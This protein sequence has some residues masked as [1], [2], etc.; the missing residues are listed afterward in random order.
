MF[1]QNAQG[2]WLLYRITAACG[3]GFLLSR[4]DQF[5]GLLN[6]KPFFATF[7]YPSVT[8]QAFKGNIQAQKQATDIVEDPSWSWY[9]LLSTSWWN[10]RYLKAIV[11]GSALQ[12][13]LVTGE[14]IVFGG[15]EARL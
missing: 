15:K 3:A 14:K 2:K 6:N 13:S 7:G 1:F 11:I 9:C 5:G 10:Q 12:K 8:I 4:Y